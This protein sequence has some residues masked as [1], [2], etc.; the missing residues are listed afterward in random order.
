M[1]DSD[2]D[3]IVLDDDGPTRL[4][5]VSHDPLLCGPFVAAL[6]KVGHTVVEREKK[7]DPIGRVHAIARRPDGAMTAVADP[8]GG[9]VGLVVQ[10][11]R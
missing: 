8:R 9:G 7:E 11:A 2:R 5:I 1:P 6:Q 3:P 4:C 10:E